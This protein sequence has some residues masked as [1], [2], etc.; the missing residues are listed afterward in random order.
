MLKSRG[1]DAAFCRWCVMSSKIVIDARLR[2]PDVPNDYV[3][4]FEGH[5][6]GRVRL[7]GAHW[8]WSIAIPMALPDWAEGASASRDESFKTLASA[9]SRL[10]SQTSPERLQRVWELEK[11]FEAREQTTA[12]AKPEGAQP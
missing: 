1:P 3:V 5:S 4:Q 10:L 9:W 8:V 2:W 12:P 6:I 11:A 7:D